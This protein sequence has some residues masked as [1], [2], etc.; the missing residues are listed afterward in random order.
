MAELDIIQTMRDAV[1]SALIA[2]DHELSE[3]ALLDRADALLATMPTMRGQ[4]ATAALLLRRNHATL[5][6]ELCRGTAPL[7]TPEVI[8]DEVRMITQ[9]VMVAV[10]VVEGISVEVAVLLALAIRAAGVA[11]LCARPPIAAG[12]GTNN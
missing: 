12:Y 4:P 3:T 1:H 6:K 2:G 10:E 11:Q 9:A 8:E 5:H 7:P